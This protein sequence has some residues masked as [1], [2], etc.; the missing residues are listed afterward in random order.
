MPTKRARALL[1]CQCIIICLSLARPWKVAGEQAAA[2]T[3]ITVVF[4]DN[5]PPYVLRDA[6]GAIRGILVDQW[7]LW[8]KKTGI[9]VTLVGMDW[10]KAQ[11]IM[12]EG[13]ADVIDTI[14]FT[15][16]RARLY[17]FTRPWATIEV[18]VFFHR[19]I[20]GIS[21]ARSLLGFTVGVKEGD[22]A[23][24]YLARNGITTIQ[25]F[26]SYEAIAL[27][28]ADQ[29]IRVFCI[30]GPP[31]R[32]FLY[33]L[34]LENEFRSTAPLYTGEF[35]R[36]VRK[37]DTE[38]L[39]TVEE[40]FARI[41]AREYAAIERKWMGTPIAMRP[42]LYRYALYGSIAVVLAALALMLWIVTLRR[43]VSLRTSQLRKTLEAQRKSE[44]KYRL[45]VENANSIIL[46]MDRRGTVS[47][48]NEFGQRFFGYAEQEIVGKSMLGTIVPDGEGSGGDLVKLIE[49]LARSPETHQSVVQENMRRGGERVWIHWTSRAVRDESGEVKEILRVGSDVTELHRA[50]AALRESEA[51]FRLLAENANDVIWTMNEAGRFT[52]VSPSVKK[53]RG[54]EPSEVLSQTMEEAVTPRS[55]A[56]LREALASF[57]SLLAAGSRSF[58]FAPI[59]VE[60]TRRDGST[61]WTEVVVTPMLDEAGRFRSLLG[62]SRDISERRQK[63]EES[64]ALQA[65]MLQAQKLESLGVL[66]G[67]IAHDFN[68]ILMAILGNAELARAALPTGSPARERVKDIDEASRRAAELCRQ[69]LAYSGRG[70]FSVETMDLSRLVR[71]MTNMLEVSVSKKAALRADL[72]EGLPSIS[73]DPTQIRQI[74]MN[75]IINASE[76][77]GDGQGEIRVRTGAMACSE[78]Y[79]TEGAQGETPAAGRYVFL[80]VEDTG[81]GMDRVTRARIFDPFFSTK[82]TGRGLGLAAVLGIVRGHGGAIR[83]TS[84][85]G[86]G[87]TFRVLFPAAEDAAVPTDPDREA[88]PWKGS[89]TVLLVDD[90]PAVRNVGKAMLE[91]IGFSVLLATDGR[92]AVDAFRDRADEIACIIL[93]LTM[94]RMGGE[95]AFVELRRIRPGA[96]IAISTGYSEEDTTRRFAGER[97]P[98]YIQ[99]PYRL[100]GL[101]QVLRELLSAVPSV[102][103]PPDFR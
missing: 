25:E 5:Y 16:E 98:A 66:A 12:A 8:E 56:V 75:L 29:K 103:E 82:F 26:A 90:E 30:D 93:D 64:R 68:N 2:I 22:A 86:S 50:E 18:P 87:T 15:E 33:K 72:P 28:A 20:S 36:A 47:F 10:S 38:L 45:L 24:D 94:P 74:V 78:E 32:Y 65:Q 97:P 91:A 37:G 27:A 55:L 34:N 53:L 23:I 52:Y 61:V 11:R 42:E 19:N 39:H 57:Y 58:D 49:Q 73:G 77:I 76:A 46:N 3:S 84:E 14:F 48:L 69:M 1:V 95:E 71:G 31:G 40:G 54:Y 67:G 89:G 59:E 6:E 63:E 81:C 44:M 79:L 102:K 85:P 7:R 21:D 70:S 96:R 100:A 35:H 99:K 83:V 4:D 88:A 17:D 41:S 9:A 13:K 80:D 101:S 92:E 51:R 60:Q 62:V 43:Q